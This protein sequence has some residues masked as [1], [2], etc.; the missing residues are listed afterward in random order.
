MDLRARR[1][2]V[3]RTRTAGGDLLLLARSHI[4]ACRSA[5]GPLAGSHAG[6]AS[7]GY[8]RLYDPKR[9][10]GPI[11]EVACWA[12][13]R[14]YFFDL[15]RLNKAPIGIEA[16]ARTDA[17][18]AIEREING[19][20]PTERRRVRQER[21]KPLVEALGAWLRQQ[22]AEVPPKGK[23]GRAIAYPG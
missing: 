20:S 21:S 4:G 12:H 2:A 18:F 7:S 9:R 6:D 16:V 1:P 15:A 11:V 3:R 14:R 10:A 13:A 17:L 5:S 19:S 23:T 8:N 22:H